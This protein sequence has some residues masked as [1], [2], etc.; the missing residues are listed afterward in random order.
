MGIMGYHGALV[1]VYDLRML[2]GYPAGGK[3]GWLAVTAGAVA[4]LAFDA[5]DGH[6][7]LLREDKASRA[8]PQASRRHVQEVLQ[9]DGKCLPV[10][11]LASVL[12]T[13]RSAAKRGAS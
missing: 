7:R 6:L 3:P 11:S 4:A 13:I 9:A 1:P 5:F 2:C 12:E 8:A 10:V